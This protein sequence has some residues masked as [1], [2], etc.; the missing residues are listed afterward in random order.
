MA[1]AFGVPGIALFF[2][3]LIG[4]LG[5]DTV[6]SHYIILNFTGLTYMIPMTLSF[7]I[8]I[9]VGHVLGEGNVQAARLRSFSGI[10]PAV[11]FSVVSATC[12]LLFPDVII[13]LY[14]NGGTVT[15]GAAMLLSYAALY[16]VSEA[17]QSSANGTMRGFKNTQIPMMLAS[18]T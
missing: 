8:T 15:Q 11:C 14:T 7:G 17:L 10:I 13:G 12:L 2:T 18:I 3:L 16:Q 6:A 5:A 4:K 9:R 1:L